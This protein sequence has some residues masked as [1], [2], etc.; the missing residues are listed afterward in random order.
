MPLFAFFDESGTYQYT[1]AQ[2]NYIVFSAVVTAT[3]TLF[4][5]EFAA[6]K[7]ELHAQ[8]TC[9]ERFHACEDTQAVRNRVFALLAGSTDFVIHS[10]VARKN[11]I[12]P[13]LYKHGVYSIAYKTLLRYL[14]KFRKLDRICIVVDTVPDQSQQ[15]ALKATLKARASE[16]LDPLGIPYTIDHHNSASH[17]LL[18]AAD[19]CA[20]AIYRKWHGNDERSYVHIR[21]RIENEYDIFGRGNTDYYKADRPGNAG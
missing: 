20:W 8:G 12:N 18:Q 14:V 19:Y 21:P 2:G 1:P 9:L 17:A 3:P 10:I 6:L 13:V 11:R 5:T 15:I 4:S 16:V 7:Y